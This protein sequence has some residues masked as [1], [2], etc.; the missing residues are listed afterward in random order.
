MSSVNKRIITTLNLTRFK[1]LG[2]ITFLTAQA[3]QKKLCYVQ[4][5]EGDTVSRI[6]IDKGTGSC[7]PQNLQNRYVASV[8]NT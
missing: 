4:N 2:I 8:I 5:L 3:L 1:S 7:F 6:S